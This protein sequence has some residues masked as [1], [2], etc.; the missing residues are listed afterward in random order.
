MGIVCTTVGAT[1]GLEY[2]FAFR[3]TPRADVSTCVGCGGGLGNDVE[4][5][6]VG[7]K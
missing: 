4:G 5:G 2:A 6:M 1:G 3:E 7:Y